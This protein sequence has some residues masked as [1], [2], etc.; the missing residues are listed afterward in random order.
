[1]QLAKNWS[2]AATRIWQANPCLFLLD[3]QE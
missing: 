1:L 3:F 2:T